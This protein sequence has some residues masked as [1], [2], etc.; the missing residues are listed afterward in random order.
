VPTARLIWNPSAGSKPGVSMPHVDERALRDVLDRHGIDA[1]ILTPSSEE[2]ARRHVRDAVRDG[3]QAVIAAGG[4]GTAELVAGEL[5]DTGTA[6]AILPLGS[7]MNLARSLGIPRDLD[8][9]AAII[10]A[11]NERLVDVGM[12][13][14]RPFYECAEV[15]LYA[16]IFPE[17]QSIDG[18]HLRAIPRLIKVLARY[19]PIPIDLR[20]DGTTLATKALLVTINNGPYGGLGFSFA[21]D[22]RLDDGCFDVRIF[23]HF[24]KRELLLHFWSIAFGRRAY[25]PHIETVRGASVMVESRGRSW[26]AD[27]WT[28]GQT[29][30]EFGIR[31]RALRVIAR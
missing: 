14:D 8:Q 10:A 11:G 9:A 15:G 4:D 1:E 16:A 28:G 20:I 25:A 22:A 30:V 17:G 12:V 27:G 29:P 19:R 23:R 24:S 7:V 26:R 21:P 13:G 3:C 31:P 5:L 18:W 2:D 6:L